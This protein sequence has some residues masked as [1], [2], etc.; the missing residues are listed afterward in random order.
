MENTNPIK[1]ACIHHPDRIG[2]CRT[3]AG[4]DLCGECAGIAEALDM[5]AAQKFF[6]YFSE[7]FRVL[8]TW[9]GGQLAL[10]TRSKR[11]KNG[12]CVRGDRLHVWA[13]ALDG[14]RWYGTGPVETGNY[15]RI[16]RVK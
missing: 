6:C 2:I 7:T 10:V 8:T 9:N 5:S 16:R 14:S 12:G 13:T 3:I 4:T 15:V 11:E 1:V